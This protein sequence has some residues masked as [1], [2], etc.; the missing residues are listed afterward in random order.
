MQSSISPA[1]R[2]SELPQK[3]AGGLLSVTNPVTRPAPVNVKDIGQTVASRILDGLKQVGCFHRNRDDESIQE[4]SFKDI[5]AWRL[6]SRAWIML[7]VDMLRLPMGIT[8]DD[9]KAP[10][11][12]RHLS[13]V[14]QMP[15]ELADQHGV[16]YVATLHEVDL[17]AAIADRLPRTVLL[18]LNQR[19]TG[20]YK[21]PIGQT[22]EGPSWVSLDNHG[23][24]LIG[25][26]TTNGKT[27]LIKSW[28]TCLCLY[29]SPDDLQLAIIDPK[30]DMLEW[31]RAAQLIAPVATRAED[32]EALIKRVTSELERRL[33]L[34]AQA[35]GAST[36]DAYN[37]AVSKQGGGRLPLLVLIVDEFISLLVQ[38]KKQIFDDL[39]RLTSMGASR[40]IKLIFT[41]QNPK[42]EY[43]ATEIRGNCSLRIAFGCNEVAQSR[44][45]L[46]KAGAEQL[47]KDVP[48]RLLAALPGKAELVE[49]QAYFLNDEA[50]ERVIRD[51]PFV[52]ATA[53]VAPQVPQSF[54]PDA[55]VRKLV[56][57]ADAQFAGAFPINEIYT[58]INAGI[59]EGQRPREEHIPKHKIEKLGKLLETEGL[60]FRGDG[61]NKPRLISD[62]LRVKCGLKP[63]HS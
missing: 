59:Q 55:F 2:V 23:H 28:L 26:G 3:A 12:L 22:R 21:V 42:A 51:L 6:E 47:P 18:D 36:L 7:H 27:R 5:Q 62:S 24:V 10:G 57:F 54:V 19:P 52:K 34:F 33:Q 20:A 41:T 30:A 48:G 45:I 37:R 60:L 16:V 25:G 29:H 43:V 1:T 11:T 13:D 31:N 14:C 32:A 40:G 49:A 9:L 39:I 50:L 61:V 15:I 44:T 56:E 58:G 53:E 8:S 4:V 35:G 38:R 46:D 17:K 63:K